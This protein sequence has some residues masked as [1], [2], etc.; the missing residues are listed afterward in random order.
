MAD[1]RTVLVLSCF[2]TLSCADESGREH[3]LPPGAEVTSVYASPTVA[4]RVDSA[5]GVEREVTRVS[6]FVHGERTWYWP[7]GEAGEDPMPAWVLCEPVASGACERIDHPYV[8]DALPGEP[9][10]SP[11]GQVHR[12]RVTD[13]YAGERLT[14]PEAIAEAV[15]EG[16][17]EEPEKRLEHLHCPVVH[18]DVRLEVAPGEW[19]EPEP[20]YYRGEQARCFDFSSTRPYGPTV[21]VEERV[22]VRNV[23]VLTREGEEA[24][25]S[26]PMRGTDL[27]GDGDT[28]DSNQIFGVGL[29]DPEYTPLW[30][31]V[32]VT[33]PAGYGSIDTSGDELVADYRDSDDMFVTDADYTISPIDGRVVSHELTGVLVDCPLQSA[34]GVL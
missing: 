11:F 2:A 31:V 16:L 15:A 13:R 22:L 25:L 6:A 32:T 20:V 8:I 14:S 17:V 10:Y 7:F 5:D 29:G 21:G 34:P 3:V 12:V 33:V 18:P 4:D 23:Y 28:N 30:R 27:T 9:A 1:T 26:E 19:V 24:P